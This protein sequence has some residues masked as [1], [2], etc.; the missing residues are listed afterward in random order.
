MSIS[1]AKILFLLILWNV[2]GIFVVLA[3]IMVMHFLM[4]KKILEKYFKPPY[5]REL[6]C[7][8]FTGIP[9]SPIRTVM[10]M[11]VF[12][13]PG[14][15]KKRKLTEAYKMAPRWYRI[16]SKIIVIAIYVFGAGAICM[17]LGYPIILLFKL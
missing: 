15:G 4:P 1:T 13:F 14:M 16:A 11:G 7:A 10:F 6:E 8:L 3:L 17:A 9:Y 5:F 2:A 12:A